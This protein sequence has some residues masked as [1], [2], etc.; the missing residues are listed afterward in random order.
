MFAAI[1]DCEGPLK[2]CV[3]LTPPSQL[4]EQFKEEVYNHFK[5]CVRICFHFVYIYDIRKFS[6]IVYT[7]RV[8][9]NRKKL[10]KI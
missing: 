9:K 6:I 7:A 3:H 5:E 1:K 8:I 4:L 10:E 2:K